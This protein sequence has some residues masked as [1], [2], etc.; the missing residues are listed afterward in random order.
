MQ[1]Y[2]ALRYCLPSSVPKMKKY[3]R[4]NVTPWKMVISKTLFTF[5]ISAFLNTIIKKIQNLSNV[6][7]HI[8]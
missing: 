4:V 6:K 1:G 5:P 7:C 3:K 2:L 8:R